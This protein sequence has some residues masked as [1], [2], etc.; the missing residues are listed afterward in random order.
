M[1]EYSHPAVCRPGNAAS[2][3]APAE[4]G[5]VGRVLVIDDDDAVGLVLARAMARLGFNADVASDGPK[6]LSIFDADPSGYSLVLLDYKLPGMDSGT[7]HRRLRARRPDL[8]VV[9]MS[10]YN[11]QEAMDN[12]A[13]LDFAGFLHKPFNIETL[14]AAL[15]FANGT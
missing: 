12:S 15:R 6:G 4:P 2:A 10:G 1:N 13:G 7:V 11:R 3:N 14:S 5:A 9:L 8:P